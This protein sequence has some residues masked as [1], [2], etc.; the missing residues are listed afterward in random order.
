MAFDWT[1]HEADTWPPA[2]RLKPP[3]GPTMLEIMRSCPLRTCFEASAVRYERRLSFSGRVGT[4]FHNTMEWLM[5]SDFTDRTP[6]E[7]A[8][9]AR[10]QFEKEMRYHI[11]EA[12]AR[13]REQGLARDEERVNRAAE[14]VISEAL[15]IAQHP[16]LHSPALR[17]VQYVVDDMSSEHGKIGDTEVEV[18]VHSHDGLFRG[19]IDRVEH[20]KT[21][22]HIVDYK[23]ALRD[24]L[25]ERYARQVQLYAKLFQ[26]TRDDWP[27]T[28]E[29]VYPLA[30]RSFPVSIDPEL[31]GDVAIEAQEMVKR[32]EQT[33][34]V[35]ELAQPGEVCKICEFRPWCKPFWD[36]QAQESNYGI[37]LQRACVGI[38][39]TIQTIQKIDY[40]WRVELK[41]RDTIVTLIAPIERFPH[42]NDASIGTVVRLLE[43]SLQGVRHRP[44]VVISPAS[45]L[46]VVL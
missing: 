30:N 7:V 46:F 34:S 27:M 4:A 42:L 10:N 18:S 45:E 33:T 17:R 14:A 9:D 41:W 5:H 29:V 19:R 1:I 2:N 12:D 38:Q 23:S 25:P 15:R 40:H 6:S 13:P 28:A 20:R 43:I 36:W 11:T 3:Y 35:E 39:C 21:G 37:A 22:I 24:E 31:C 26:E 32:L 16:S 44:R 8:T